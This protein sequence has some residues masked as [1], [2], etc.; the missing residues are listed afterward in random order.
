MLTGTIVTLVASV[1]RAGARDAG[2]ADA[3][4]ARAAWSSRPPSRKTLVFGL[5]V[6]GLSVGSASSTPAR[7]GVSSA[8]RV[9]GSPRSLGIF[10]ASLRSHRGSCA[11]CP[12]RRPA[13]ARLVA[14][15]D[16]SRRRTRCATGRTASTAAGADDRADARLV[17]RRL[18]KRCS[19]ATRT[20]SASTRHE[21]RDHLAEVGGHRAGRSRQGRAAAR[22]SSS[23]RRSAATGPSCSA[24][25]RSTSAASTEHD[26]QGVQVRWRE[27]PGRAGDARQGRRRRPRGRGATSATGSRSSHPPASK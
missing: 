26:R 7:R 6:T 13:A 25:A 18:G 5:V 3:A 19:R 8:V 9:L 11:R 15:P 24:A 17:R 23:A 16:G 22:A 1:W 20:R 12:S 2:S 27:A 4:C 14:L 10:I 21:P